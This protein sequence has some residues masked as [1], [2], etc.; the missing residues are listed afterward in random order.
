MSN[1]I[2]QPALKWIPTLWPLNEF[3]A[4]NPM[5]DCTD[6]PFQEVLE[7]LETRLPDSNQYHVL[8]E[9]VIK[10][11]SNSMMRMINHHQSEDICLL[12]YRNTLKNQKWIY[13]K[14]MPPASL[15]E[16]YQWVNQHLHLNG[17][18]SWQMIL[19]LLWPVRGWIGWFKWKNQHED[20]KVSLD[21]I[22]SLW[23]MMIVIE[24][25]IYQHIL[26]SIPNHKPAHGLHIDENTMIMDIIN[27]SKQSSKKNKHRNTLW[28][29]CIDSR[30][31]P[32]RRELE[33]HGFATAGF[34]G[35]FNIP[36]NMFNPNT[37]KKSKQYPVLLDS[38]KEIELKECHETN[39]MHQLNQ[40]I[41]KQRA[42][43]KTLG[44][45]F[46]WFE[47]NALLN[48]IYLFARFSHLKQS[49]THLHAISL[50]SAD[51]VFG[52]LS[53]DEAISLVEPL[54]SCIDMAHS[55]AKTV[56]LCGHESTID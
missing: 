55:S 4:S 32:L 9:H 36:L 7:T 46:A 56:V 12:Q 26:N 19:T 37:H 35:F 1:F 39:A 28:V 8:A 33:N 25:D 31:E 24:Q 53:K 11:Y 51:D 34:A 50:L 21:F 43:L 16:F 44:G 29:L 3:V 22:V 41:E 45:A 15:N 38:H 27:A 2:W 52:V 47:T 42:N 20:E 40:I 48:L 18:D 13:I 23:L 5:S 14:G 17:I 54:L 10:K 30:S 49:P 6:L